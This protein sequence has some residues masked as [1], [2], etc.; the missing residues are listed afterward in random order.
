MKKNLILLGCIVILAF[1]F[2]ACKDPLDPPPGPDPDTNTTIDISEIE[3]VVVPVTHGFPVSS[4]I[5]TEQFTG[6]VEWSP[7]VSIFGAGQT[8]TA[9]IRLTPRPGYTVARVSANFFEVDGAD[10][11][12]N[13]ANSGVITAVFPETESLSGRV[14]YL[15][16]TGNDDTGDGSIENPWFSMQKANNQAEP[17]DTYYLRGGV[18]NYT[19]AHSDTLNESY[20][21]GSYSSGRPIIRLNRSGTAGNPITYTAYPEDTERPILN[22]SG[23]TRTTA[24]GFGNNSGSTRADYIILNGFDIRG[25]PSGGSTSG[26]YNV[27]Y[28]YAGSWNTISNLRIYENA[29]TGIFVPN[30]QVTAYNLILNVDSFS[31]RSL[32]SASANGSIDG[33][34]FHIQQNSVGNVVKGCR[35]WLCGDDGIDLINCRATVVID[36][37]WCA[38]QG[39]FYTADYNPTWE[40]IWSFQFEMTQAARP[41]TS[42]GGGRAIADNG[43]GIKAGGFDM[44]A[45]V[46]QAPTMFPRQVVRFSLSISN[47]HTG[48]NTNHQYGNGNTFVNNSGWNNN[49]NFRFA[50]RAAYS[51]APYIRQAAGATGWPTGSPNY[52]TANVNA[53]D[54]VAKNNVSLGGGHWAGVPVFGL[55]DDQKPYPPEGTT[56]GSSWRAS[57]ANGNINNNYNLLWAPYQVMWLDIESGT[58]ENNSWTMEDRGGKA[59]HAYDAWS[60]ITLTMVRGTADT[61]YANNWQQQIMDINQNP[62]ELTDD[63]FFS[64]DETLFFSPRN[65]DGSLPEIDLLRP[66]PGT[67]PYNM[68]MG[69][70]ALDLNEDGYGN[71]W[72]MVG[73]MP[74]MDLVQWW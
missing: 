9:T 7:N 11:V 28:L 51:S 10:S 2:L 49:V 53:H 27:I 46:Q 18:Y 43:N 68:G 44:T 38:Y 14:F 59:D 48:F 8:Y 66:K 71:A 58:I 31:N 37:F 40:D 30:G 61:P 72:K 1:A 29:G 32:T 41:L 54:I 67:V 20:S 39:M 62:Y 6:T 15:A 60:R 36:G 3:G 56:V 45:S 63:D 25:L 24:I 65:P 34:G 33:F 17:G 35:S 70:T 57:E 4:I 13:S 47:P 5:A 50:H 19:T 12:V 73:A 55:V 64:L 69:Y 23:V 21:G 74:Q 52:P 22:M 42:T 16:P 26:A